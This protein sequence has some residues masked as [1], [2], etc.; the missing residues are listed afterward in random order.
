MIDSASKLILVCCYDTS[1]NLSNLKPAQVHYQ[2][3]TGGK[4]PGLSNST[5]KIYRDKDDAAISPEE[6]IVKEI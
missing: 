3:R 2:K 4:T 1:P 5:T 6:E